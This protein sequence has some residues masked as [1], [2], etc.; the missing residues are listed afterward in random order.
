MMSEKAEGV[1]SDFTSPA[2]MGRQNQQIPLRSA[3]GYPGGQLAAKAGTGALSAKP[4][5]VG[6]RPV[7][8]VSQQIGKSA[9]PGAARPSAMQRPKFGLTLSQDGLLS[10]CLTCI[11]LVSSFYLTQI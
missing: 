7:V 5:A 11:E 4:D 10:N 6:I 2:F 8:G 9:A 3:G 1:R